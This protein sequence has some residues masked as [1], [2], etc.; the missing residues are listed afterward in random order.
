M[1]CVYQLY[2][3]YRRILIEKHSLEMTTLVERQHSA[4]IKILVSTAE[5]SIR[6]T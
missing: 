4:G 2:F 5:L 6:D 1:C 3:D